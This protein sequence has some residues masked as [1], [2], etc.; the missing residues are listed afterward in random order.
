MKI[1]IVVEGCEA[2]A[3]LDYR[4][5]K[6]A[7]SATWSTDADEVTI[8][9]GMSRLWC[10]AYKS[11]AAM[12]ATGLEEPEAA[13]EALKSDYEAI[14]RYDKLLRPGWQKARKAV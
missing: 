12:E 9:T 14:S 5:H 7:S 11:W 8:A 4:G 1:T 2:A 10:S 13:M 3:E 6:Y